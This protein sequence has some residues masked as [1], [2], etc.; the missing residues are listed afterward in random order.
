MWV[1]CT[2]VLGRWVGGLLFVL[3]L[4]KEEPVI[5]LPAE[6]VTI[7]HRPVG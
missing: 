2:F 7:A 6:S 1:K 5:H 3:L 4:G